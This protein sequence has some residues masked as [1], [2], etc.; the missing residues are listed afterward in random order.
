MHQT[1][2]A[3]H[4][5]S[6]MLHQTSC[7][8]QVASNKLHQTCWIKHVA[9]NML[10]QTCCIE[11]VAS[12]MLHRTCCIE[13][14]E[15]NMLHQTSCIKYFASYLHMIE[16][17]CSS[18]IDQPNEFDN[19]KI[20]AKFSTGKF[21]QN[22]FSQYQAN[23]IQQKVFFDKQFYIFVYNSETIGDNDIEFSLYDRK[24]H[25][26]FIKIY[27]RPQMPRLLY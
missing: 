8:K 13:H 25:Q 26:L 16:Q 3:K 17:T 10:N 24:K 4:V 19:L 18:K 23:R 9:S 22:F 1:C 21:V 7:I 14:V 2:C 6:N 27:F 11:H 15:S 5:A 20:F 12:N